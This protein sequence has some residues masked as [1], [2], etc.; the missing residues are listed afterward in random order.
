MFE[1]EFSPTSK[2]DNTDLSLTSTPVSLHLLEQL[3]WIILT[4][5]LNCFWGAKFC[6]P[7]ALFRL[8][9]SDV[10]WIWLRIS[11]EPLSKRVILPQPKGHT[12]KQLQLL[13]LARCRRHH[14]PGCCLHYSSEVFQCKAHSM[15]AHFSTPRTL[16]PRPQS[17]V[18]LPPVSSHRSLAL[19]MII[20]IQTRSR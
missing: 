19:R 6:E 15:T 1:T 13:P 14:R 17:A 20:L 8:S 10:S 7:D 3:K 2:G 12:E 18:P 5:H 16:F 9:F 11:R 4:S